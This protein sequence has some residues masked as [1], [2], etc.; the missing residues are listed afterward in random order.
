MAGQSGAGRSKAREVTGTG[1]IRD[2]IRTPLSGSHLPIKVKGDEEITLYPGQGR[3]IS[4]KRLVATTCIQCA[5]L[6][7]ASSAGGTRRPGFLPH[8]SADST[9]KLGVS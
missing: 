1:D 8:L 4:L 6:E 9:D 5:V 7:D 3:Q 2:T